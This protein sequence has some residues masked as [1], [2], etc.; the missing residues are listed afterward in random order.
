MDRS[1]NVI[2][3][4]EWGTFKD[5]LKAPIFG[6]F[7]YPAGFS[8]KAVEYSFKTVGIKSG[9]TVYD[10]FMGSGTTNLVAKMM[11]VNSYGVEAHPF[12]FPIT[13]C[14]L[15][16]EVNLQKV[17]DY[18]IKIKNQIRE[19][20][21]KSEKEITE[22][23]E[24]EFPDLVL[25]CFLPQTLYELLLVRN[26]IRE[27]DDEDVRLFLNTGLICTLRTVS[28]AATGWPY[29]APKKI[30]I[31]SFSK[32]G[33]DTY[34]NFISKMMDDIQYFRVN[35]ECNSF[36]HIFLGDSSDTKNLIEDEVAD[37]I[38]TSPP[39]L[40]NFDYADRTRLEM[41]FMGEANN[42]N[43]ICF[44]VRTKLMTSSTTQINRT[45]P[46]YHFSE[47]FQLSCPQEFVFLQN[48]VNELSQ[49]RLTK[50]GKKSYDYLVIGYFNDIFQIIKDNYRILKKGCI[51]RYILGD[52]APY[53]IHIPTDELIGKIGRNIGFKDYKIDILRGR[54]DKWKNNPQR[55]GVKLRETIVT[56]IK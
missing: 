38:F 12:V 24:S 34:I 21:Q 18:I 46:K 1:Y 40:N 37:H 3:N 44:N 48:A 7:T 55:H 54:G 27:I 50:G 33:L 35:F 9:D 13:K 26:A 25:R 49:I 43:D 42:W 2:D 20:I 56:L 29:I 28:I 17:N 22:I 39:Y 36:H 47:E 5:S 19:N 32:R 23:L 16:W 6:W 15:N 53:G 45:N 41:Y 8:F 11:G 52:S 31:T 4:R 14:K 10:P 30:K 51:A